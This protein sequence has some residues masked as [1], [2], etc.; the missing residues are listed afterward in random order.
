M[1]TRGSELPPGTLID[2]RYRIQRV[3]GRGGFGRTYLASDQRRFGELCVL[4]EF[5]P[6]NQGDSV[7]AHKLHE[8]FH[9]EAK[10]LHQLNHPQIPKFF[11]V[12]E[13]NDRL[14]IAQEYINGK[15]YWKL[16]Q[17]RQ[18]R[19]TTFGEAEVIQWLQMLLPVLDY[20]HR[21]NIVHRDISP[22]NI[23]L[24]NQGQLPVLIDFGVVKQAAPHWYEVSSIHPDGSIQ[25]SVSVGKLGYAPYE[26]I[27][28]GQCSPRSDLYAL[29][30][31]AVVLLTAKPPNLL[32]DSKSLEWKWHLLTHVDPQLVK[33]L[34]TMMAE[35]P[36][37]RYPSAKAVLQDLE[38]LHP[39]S[40]EIAAEV[41]LQYD[42]EGDLV[43]T[44]HPATDLFS[45]PASSEVEDLISLESTLLEAHA[46]TAVATLPQVTGLNCIHSS[47]KELAQL[48]S[49]INTLA[50][51]T[52]SHPPQPIVR[53]RSTPPPALKHSRSGNESLLMGSP[54]PSTRLTVLVGE[55]KLPSWAT[56][57]ALAL[58]SLLLLPLGGIAIG[59]QSPYISS[60]CQTLNNCADG[61]HIG[62]WYDRAI[63]Q[64]KAAQHLLANAK[65]LADLQQA[66]DRLSTSITQLNNLPT[67]SPW[68]VSAQQVLP[69]YREQLQ[70][71]QARLERETRASQLLERAATEAQ[72]AE[73]Q[74]KAARSPQ[75]REKAQ[76]QWR[77]AIATLTAIPDS[78]LIAD[79]AKTRSQE[80][81][82]RLQAIVSPEIPQTVAAA[83]PAPG[84][85]SPQPSASPS[86]VTAPSSAS[87]PRATT[88]SAS[89]AP[90]R[91]TPAATAPAPRS[92]A[93]PA[94]SQRPTSTRAPQVAAQP[95]DSHAFS[96]P[97]S[98]LRLTQPPV[99]ASSSAPAYP[100]TP[101]AP[102]RSPVQLADRPPNYHVVPGNVALS[103]EQTVESVSV[104]L[105]G[106]RISSSGTFVANLVVENYSD[107]S[108]G[109]VPLFVEVR[110]AA[111]HRVGS[112]VSFGGSEDAMV[113]P[114]EMLQGEVY[115]LDR[116]WD[117]SGSQDL[118]LVIREGTSGNRNFYVSF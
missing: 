5:V 2:R 7:V 14:F 83:S 46:S 50:E 69:S 47:S 101:S 11:A 26:Q 94:P 55:S 85:A 58:C 56:R 72:Q 108:F 33:I 40:T 63:Q 95:P 111:G 6:K 79:Q 3:L 13:E 80:Y 60:L 66:H 113:A 21:R 44:A 31:T 16:L 51:A 96:P 116:Y 29:G 34:Q 67:S 32:I 10:I 112:R 84:A 68:F 89:P 53:Q 37:D 78:V 43:A 52:P 74:T 45:Q 65:D 102:S 115:L 35:K 106:A 76:S 93:Q 41:M 109:F 71:L 114:G 18:H 118:T 49:H 75:D 15:T 4:K 107:R 98:A 73:Q 25:A 24:P 48:D 87:Q 110:D 12:F 27:R 57:K 104:R 88:S 99:S 90:T 54:P 92:K 62:Q 103:A 59:I 77:K 28:I 19:G 30:V 22:D 86:S 38:L 100:S 117:S 81:Q 61:S 64:A 70:S 42:D 1:V 91:T 36:Q 105:E 20:L 17:E 39:L 97:A 82:A 23:M 8:L 9:R